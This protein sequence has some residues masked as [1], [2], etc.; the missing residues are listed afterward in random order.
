M[1]WGCFID[2]KLGPIVFIH[3]TV[4]SK[5]YIDILDQNLIPF[6][7]VLGA[8]GITNVVFQQD[9]ATAHTAKRT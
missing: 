8:D 5:A 4:N 2:N 3:G 9:N 6:I 1:I 7:D